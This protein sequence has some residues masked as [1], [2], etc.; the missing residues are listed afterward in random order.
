MPVQDIVKQLQAVGFSGYEAKAYVALVSAGKPLNGYEVAKRA[1]VPRSTVYE[2]LNKLVARSA[3]FEVQTEGQGVH[4][5]PLQPATLFAR[6]RDQ[7]EAALESLQS[8]FEELAVDRSVHLTHTLH[9]RE[10]ILARCADAISSASRE[11]LLL[12]SPEELAD[13]RG[14]LGRAHRADVG[15]IMMYLG[16]PEDGVGRV[17]EHVLYSPEELRELLGCRLLVLVSDR[18]H[19]VI[20][21]MTEHRSWGV[22]TDDPAVVLLG[23]E[24]IR[25]D[26]KSQHVLGKLGEEARRVWHE[27]GPDLTLFKVG[28]ASLLRRLGEFDTST[29]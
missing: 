18:E 1:G 24:F 28:S 17:F 14:V 8:L 20:A 5:L 3:A 29:R 6:V 22:F 10:E 25:L 15:V 27:S 26:I 16:P 7:T 9:G 23:L 21:G 12:L 2:T 4:Y 19:V 11:V 13:L